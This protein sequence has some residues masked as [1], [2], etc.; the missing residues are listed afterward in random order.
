MFIAS[1]DPLCTFLKK[2]SIC[3]KT[4]ERKSTLPSKKSEN[5]VKSNYSQICKQLFI[6]KGLS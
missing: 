6:K 3:I 2:V 1:V 4:F 5:V